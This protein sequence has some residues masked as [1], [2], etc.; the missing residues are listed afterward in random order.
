M[1]IDYAKYNKILD[2]YNNVIPHCSGQPDD[3]IH[4][5]YVN[6]QG[7]VMLNKIQQAHQYYI[8]LDMLNTYSRGFNTYTK[9]LNIPKTTFDNI[10]AESDKN[11]NKE[12]LTVLS[13]S[14][15]DFM[16]KYI[17]TNYEN[18]RQHLTNVVKEK[19]PDKLET[20]Q[21]IALLV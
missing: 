2:F 11:T 4:N 16:I 21:K 7:S 6:D 14:D 15:K 18:L 9:S 1:N 8:Q 3:N 17:M 13:N 10:E 20:L 12:L 5:Y 19:F